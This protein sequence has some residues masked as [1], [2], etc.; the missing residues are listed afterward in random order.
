MSFLRRSCRALW[1]PRTSR[2]SA[3]RRT[4]SAMM[5][6]PECRRQNKKGTPP[7][8]GVP[9]VLLIRGSY[10]FK[11]RPRLQEGAGKIG[12]NDIRACG[13]ARSAN[14]QAGAGSSALDAV[15]R[16]H[17]NAAEPRT[18]LAFAVLQTVALDHVEKGEL[19]LHEDASLQAP[20]HIGQ[21]QVHCTDTGVASEQATLFHKA[22][23]RFHG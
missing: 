10:Y 20:L 18:A 5:T 15:R 6:T 1:E 16:Q 2:A 4:D 8:G 11:R 12:R 13:L 17:G 7:R 22:A 23:D 21:V 3:T 19:V 9:R 14:P